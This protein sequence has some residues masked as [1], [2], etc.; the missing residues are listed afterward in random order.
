MKSLIQDHGVDKMKA[1][2]WDGKPFSVSVKTIPIPRLTKPTDAIIRCT[3]SGIC[4]SDL[5]VFHGRLPAH[6][7]MTLGHEIVGIVHSI[8]DLVEDL[9][10]G[11]RVIVSGVL[12]EDGL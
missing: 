5:H 6:P 8:G 2:E 1:V 3:T 4:G 10:I 11:D 12:F 9:K 7:P